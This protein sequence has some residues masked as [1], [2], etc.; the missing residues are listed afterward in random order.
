MFAQLLAN[1]GERLALDII[2]PMGPSSYTMWA[3]TIR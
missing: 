3:L 2:G 1:L